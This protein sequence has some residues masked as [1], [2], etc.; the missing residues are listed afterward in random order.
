MKRYR[1]KFGGTPDSMAALA[2]DAAYVAVA[3]MERAPDLSGPALR[4]AIAA[5]KGFV[6]VGGTVTLDADHN[7]VKAAVVLRI[8]RNKAKYLATVE[9]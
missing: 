3:A 5:T 7:A 2:Y 8:E 4:D 9:P 1:E 6:G